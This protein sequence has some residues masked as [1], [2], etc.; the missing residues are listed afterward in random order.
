[1]DHGQASDTPF[2]TKQIH[3]ETIAVLACI[4]GKLGSHHLRKG[5]QQI[6]LANGFV[7]SGSGL[8]LRRPANEKGHAMPSL[9]DGSFSL[10]VKTVRLVLVELGSLG[11]SFLGTVIAGEYDQGIFG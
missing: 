1:M 10:A 11:P 4:G 8:H 6:G 7:P 3:V 2:P 9:V 5:G